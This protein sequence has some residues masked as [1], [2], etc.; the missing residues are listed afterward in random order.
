MI[1]VSY[2]STPQTLNNL[3]LFFNVECYLCIS[4]GCCDILTNPSTFQSRLNH[5][6]G[7]LFWNSQ[8]LKRFKEVITFQKASALSGPERNA[9]PTV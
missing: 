3:P 2:H 4:N 7:L 6:K 8:D 5:R 9:V 1:Q